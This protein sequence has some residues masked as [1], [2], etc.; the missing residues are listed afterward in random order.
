MK[1]ISIETGADGIAIITLDNADESV[2]L[3]SPE[4]ISEYSAAVNQLAE[5]SSVTGVIVT[6]AKRLFMAGAD[7]KFLAGFHDSGKSVAEA[8]AFSQ[9][10]SAMHRRMETSGKPFVAAING[11]ALGGGFEL[12]LACHGRI[13][14]DD[15]KA[16]VGLPEVKVGLLPGSG[17]TQRLVRLIGVETGLDLLL[18]GTSLAPAEALRLGLVDQVVPAGALMTA[19]RDWLAAHPD[20]VQVWDK[21]G[22]SLP[23]SAGLLNPAAAMFFSFKSAKA[24]TMGRNY[25]APIAITSAVFEGVQLTFDGALKI[26]SKYFAKLLTGVVAR[27]IIRTNFINK[28]AA[29]RLIHRPAHVP[30]LTV[31]KLGVLGAGLMGSG[32]A[33]VAAGV[34]IEVVLLDGTAARAAQGKAAIAVTLGKEV[35]R[36]KRTQEVAGAILARITT[37][38]DYALLA[39]CDLVVEAVFEDAGV[40]AEVTAKAEAVLPDQAVFATNTSTLPITGLAAA[41]KR[42]DQFIGLHFFSPVERMALVEVIVGKATSQETLARGLDFVAQLRKTPIVVNDHR[43][44]F[45]SRVFATYTHEGMAMLEEGISPARIENGARQAGMPIGPLA[46]LDEV[47]LDLTY[48]IIQA[49]TA[50]LGDAYKEPVGTNVL[51][52]MIEQEKRPSRRAGGGFYEYPAGGRKHI[53]PGLAEIYPLAEVQPPIEDIKNR[54][55]FVQA[56]EAARCLEDNVLMHAADGDI[57]SVLG[58]GF[59]TWTGGVLSLIDTV[60]IAQF[61]Q[62]CDGLAQKYG[63]RFQPSPWLR[64]RAA[65]GQ[66][67][68]TENIQTPAAA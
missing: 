11:A 25:P 44:F 19:A 68:L 21:K 16:V 48:K 33:S 12:C 57:G 42:P 20:P 18:E 10:A 14:V 40:K 41:S 31:K 50:E 51:R 61:V 3:V 17:G 34:G 63:K 60:G 46:L 23:E 24:T 56:M 28:G 6:S 4:F 5:D 38:D 45:T 59:P 27:N 65:A 49:A 29:E 47:T 53:W 64:A 43:G 13:I 62:A 39:G 32:I 55:L 8:F 36:K 54:F 66:G 52:R 22:F 67:F 7:L 26:E 35:E 9:Q 1:H 30:K 37:T 58:W 15:P 2:N